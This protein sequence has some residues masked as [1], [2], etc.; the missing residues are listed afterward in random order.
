MSFSWA[1]RW[2]GVRV[3]GEGGMLHTMYSIAHMRCLDDASTHLNPSSVDTWTANKRFMVTRGSPGRWRRFTSTRPSTGRSSQEKKWTG[4]HTVGGHKVKVG[5]FWKYL[6]GI[7]RNTEFYTELTLFRVI[8]RNSAE[9]F[10]V[11]Y[12]EIPRNSVYGIP[13]A[14]KWKFNQTKWSTHMNNE[15]DKTKGTVSRDFLSLVFLY[16]TTTPSPNR[17]EQKQ[18]RIFPNIHGVI[19]TVFVIDSLVMNTPGSRLESLGSKAIFPNINHM[20]LCS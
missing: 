20:F 1:R 8:P 2:G 19:R 18:F 7:L 10:T 4:G 9:F 11:Q 17:H 12:R 13:Y 14:F 3:R 16:H 5:C 6:L 15:N